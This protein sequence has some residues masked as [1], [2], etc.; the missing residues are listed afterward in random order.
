MA[1]YSSRSTSIFL[2]NDTAL[3]LDF[4]LD[5]LP[6]G[7]GGARLRGQGLFDEKNSR[8]VIPP[9]ET[10]ATKAPLE[11]LGLKTSSA[12][13][14]KPPVEMVTWKPTR[15]HR[16]DVHLDDGSPFA[17][18]TQ[19]HPMYLL[20]LVS[21]LAILVCLFLASRGGNIRYQRLK[22]PKP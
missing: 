3:T 15:R 7:A 5:P 4:I 8:F 21:V 20:P 18:S 1:G 10:A 22:T 12:T 11:E 13:A 6:T 14:Q 16:K 9:D 17:F 2:P 19:Y